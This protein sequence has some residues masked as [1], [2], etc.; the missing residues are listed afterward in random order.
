MHVFD[1][2]NRKRYFAG[3]EPSDIVRLVQ[4]LL[5]KVN[6]TPVAT[7]SR[8]SQ[9]SA[10]VSTSSQLPL[11]APEAS[12]AINRVGL[13]PLGVP[14][15][16]ENWTFFGIE[17]ERVPDLVA[18][19][20]EQSSGFELAYRYG[21]APSAEDSL[22]DRS[23]VWTGGINSRE[24]NEEDVYALGQKLGL[25]SIVMCWVRQR[26]ASRFELDVHVFDVSNGQHY[27]ATGEPTDAKSLV[28][29]LLQKVGR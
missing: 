17:L 22:V 3:G 8:Q 11:T 28:V 25:H 15:R 19:A 7:V 4:T 1:V 18:E 10:T 29:Q 23:G 2:V 24:P 12:S 14:K 6:Q 16:Q 26:S 9:P 5:A 20:V 13:F 21:S 27:A